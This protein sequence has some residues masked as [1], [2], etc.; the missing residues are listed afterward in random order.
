MAASGRAPI[1]VGV[2]PGLTHRAALAWGADEASRRRAP[3]HLLLAQGRP[4]GST[5]RRHLHGGGTFHERRRLAECALRD[6]AAFVADRHPRLEVCALPAADDP[7]PLLR[8]E[9]RTAGT[10]VLGARRAGTRK[11]PFTSASVALP[12][13]AHAACPVVVVRGPGQD[14][15]PSRHFVVG[16]DVGVDGRR[17]SAAAVDHAFAEAA[18]HRATLRVLY[19]W[20]PP[21]LGVMDEHAALR[22]CRE[23]LSEMVENR[24]AAYRDVEVHHD[25]VR[26][27]PAQVLARESAHALGLVVGVRGNG[28]LT[29]V[30]PGSVVHGVLH[31]ARC[32][33]VAVPRRGGRG[34]WF[35]RLRVRWA[36][37]R[38]CRAA[39]RRARLLTG[40]T[41]SWSATVRGRCRSWLRQ[42]GHAWRGLRTRR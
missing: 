35:D 1:V 19:V 36:A 34:T 9:A 42:G 11:G 31:R 21:L 24:R 30:L 25:V 40:S 3:L 18:L 4:E 17:H 39:R 7:V 38:A 28:G 32:P 23:L 2:A 37:R 20:H 16:V 10:V 5:P 22:E 8:R 6:A 15:A 12:V 13:I 14:A 29:G 26:G 33:V 27:R 41:R